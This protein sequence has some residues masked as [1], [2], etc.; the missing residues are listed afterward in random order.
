MRAVLGDRQRLGARAGQAADAAGQSEFD[1]VDNA[2]FAGPVGAGD[3]ERLLIES[4]VEV[5]DAA[6]LLNM[7]VLKAYHVKSLPAGAAKTFTSS[8]T[9]IFLP[10]ANSSSS[11][12]IFPASTS[13]DWRSFSKYLDAIVACSV[14][15]WKFPCSPVMAV[16]PFSGTF[17]E[18]P[19]ELL[20]GNESGRAPAG[21]I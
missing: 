2:A 17:A 4:D 7:R 5:A 1:S 15:T 11:C 6:H 21:V 12:A 16:G 20:R 18:L 3:G 19:A 10:E 14:G 9:L 8:S 13:S